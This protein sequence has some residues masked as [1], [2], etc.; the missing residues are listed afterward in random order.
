EL[1]QGLLAAQKDTAAAGAQVTV[2]HKQAFTGL[3]DGT[4]EYTLVY[5]DNEGDRMLVG[6]DVPWE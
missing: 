3:L 4:G 6:D 1:F 2:E 5:E